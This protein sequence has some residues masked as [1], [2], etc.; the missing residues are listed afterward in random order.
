MMKEGDHVQLIASQTR[1][2][3]KPTKKKLK[4][5]FSGDIHDDSLFREHKT[6]RLMSASC[7]GTHTGG[8]I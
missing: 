3:K 1:T 5:F 6:S 8:R 7:M 2:T 4:H